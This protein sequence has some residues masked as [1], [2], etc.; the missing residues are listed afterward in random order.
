MTQTA[1]HTNLHT[2]M[3]SLE[4]FTRS[5][6]GAKSTLTVQAYRSDLQQFF[7]WLTETD[8][9]VTSVERISRNHIEDYFAHLA[10]SSKSCLDG[11]PRF[12]AVLASVRTILV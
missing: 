5:L 1:A 10:D 3:L 12:T 8:Y 4:E 9:T 2:L 7:T 6:N 11:F